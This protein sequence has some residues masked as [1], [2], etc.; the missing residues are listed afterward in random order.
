VH[1]R[2]EGRT[3]QLKPGNA[4]NQQVD[5]PAPSEG[6]VLFDPQLMHVNSVL[7]AHIRIGH[8]RLAITCRSLTS[9]EY[10]PS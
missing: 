8:E 3:F 10:R 5:T 9:A 2:N 6:R 7:T 1:Q 4:A